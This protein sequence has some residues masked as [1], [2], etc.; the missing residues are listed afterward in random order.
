MPSTPTPVT[1]NTELTQPENRVFYPALDGLRA[2]AFLL[3]FLQHYFQF[4]WGWTGVN[5][6]FVL[7]GFLITGILYDS[8]NDEHKARNFYVRRTLRIFPLFYAVFLMLLLLYPA[9]HWHWSAYWIAWPLYIA[10]F[11]PCL[12]SAVSTNGSDLQLAAFG[13]I[14]PAGVPNFCFYFGHFWSL[15]VEEQFYFIWPWIVFGVRSRRTL[16]YICGTVVILV[17]VARV[18]CQHTAP[19]WLL[20]ADLLDRSTPFQIDS[21]LL[22]ALV[23][24]AVRGPNSHR[25]YSIG[26]VVAAFTFVVALSVLLSGIARSYPDWRSGY[27]Y[28]EWKFTWGLTLIDFLSAGIIT[29]AL[30]QSNW[31]HRVLR[32][33]TLRWIG[34]ISY[35]A[36]VF[37]DI[38]HDVYT[39][40]VALIAMHVRFVASHAVL[41]VGILGL[42]CTLLISW[43]SFECFE[44]I[45]LNYKERWTI[46]PASQSSARFS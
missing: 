25:L 17:P 3:V 7:S 19:T 27:V 21:L 13:W 31:I 23:A 43:L 4:P 42:A 9:F 5:I 22:G 30:H 12:S 37:H 29:L 24:L 11:L 20:H 1:G 18:L 45:F 14:H 41:F 35:G 40:I 16:T 32:L 44:S 8:R 39:G 36:Y 46:R 34:R 10:N 38:F 26:K 33:R 2:I 28:P 15:C 6:F